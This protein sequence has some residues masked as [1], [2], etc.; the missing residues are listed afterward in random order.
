[1]KIKTSTIRRIIKEEID[2]FANSDKDFARYSNR[3]SDPTKSIKSN[4][5][6]FK[7]LAWYIKSQ[8]KDAFEKAT[9]RTESRIS[10]ATFIRS[11][12]I[13]EFSDAADLEDIDAGDVGEEW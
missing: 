8:A 7:K 9:A 11:Y 6:D 2:K 5:T 4:G 1:M 10:Y 12:L 3:E 13:H